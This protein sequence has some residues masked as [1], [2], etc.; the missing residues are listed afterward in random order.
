MDSKKREQNL[1]I[2]TYFALYV[3]TQ[4]K[5]QSHQQFKGLFPQNRSNIQRYQRAVEKV[6]S[7]KDDDTSDCEEALEW[8]RE[9]N[10]EKEVTDLLSTLGHSLH[11]L[12]WFSH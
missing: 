9:H 5:T 6:L 12:H 11:N 4:S 8:I 1:H 10:V 3:I 7:R 2:G